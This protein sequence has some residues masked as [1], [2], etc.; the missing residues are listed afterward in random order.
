MER[1]RITPLVAPV[2]AEVSIPGSKSYTNRALLIAALTPRPVKI[3]NPLLSD[4]TEAMMS[5]LT[6]LGLAVERQSDHLLVRGGVAA[7]VDKDY[8]L[9]ANLSGTTI[10]FMLALAAVIPGRQTL[11][12]SEGL[13]QR[14]IGDLVYALQQLGAT[15]EYL[16]QDGYPP[17]RVT[18]SKLNP[19]AVELRGDASSQYLSALLM[20]APLVGNTA[21]HI[22]GALGSKPF[23]DMT[24]QTM[25][26]CGVEV[27]NQNYQ[28]F[29]IAANQ[30]YSAD[31]Y[32][33]EGDVSSASY[34]MAIAAL[35]GSIL[36]LTN[37]NPRSIQADMG[38]VKILEAMGN[39]V[40]YDDDSLTITG[41]SVRP[42]AVNMEDCPDQ[43]QTLAVLAAFAPG[44]TTI[45]GIQSLRIKET[46]RVKA[47]EQELAKMGIKTKS[48][49]ST[50][51]IYG[52]Q[53]QAASIAT[54]GDHR[55]AMAFAVAGT[56][57]AGLEIQDPA[58]VSKTFP[59]FWNKLASIGVGIERLGS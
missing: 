22:V 24:M 30:T 18:S 25:R 17:L 8:D 43:A 58:V 6:A 14:P 55:M 31:E 57:L 51:T 52:G 7:I 3:I 35:T 49:H 2:E 38:F 40:T 48:T 56:K 26:Q 4:D 42:V 33:V 19:G 15:I 47:L 9:N 1:L 46:E 28:H 20:V 36:T 12:G 44:V 10:R 54:Y 13:R 41:S 59:D 29:T 16:D 37:M 45:N 5:C 27:V 39:R 21:I 32:M 11:T 50:L 53:P 34:F 23:V